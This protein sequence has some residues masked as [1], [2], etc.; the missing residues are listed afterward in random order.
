MHT[1]LWY[2]LAVASQSHIE[3][4]TEV[5]NRTVESVIPIW[6][7][8]II[9]GHVILTQLA[10]LAHSLYMKRSMAGSSRYNNIL[11]FIGEM[12]EASED[13]RIIYCGC[14]VIA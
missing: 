14:N 2:Y 9:H 3:E 13:V 1:E 5:R 4:H 6:L 10:M 11:E 8:N 7:V 12:S